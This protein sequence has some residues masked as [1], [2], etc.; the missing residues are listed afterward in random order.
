MTA[1]HLPVETERKAPR[2]SA[3]Q[4]DQLKAAAQLQQK[5]HSD[6]PGCGSEFIV[7][8][9]LGDQPGDARELG[10]GGAA[11]LVGPALKVLVADDN[12]DAA[13]TCATL[14]EVLGHRVE[15]AYTGQRALELAGRFQ[16]H[17]LLLDI[18]LPDLNGYELAKQIRAA[19]WARRTV[20]I[21]VTG[22]G[23]EEHQRRALEAGF[24]HHLTKPLAAETLE[25]LLQSVSSMLRGPGG[26]GRQPP[27]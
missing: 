7:R 21:A 27:C 11:A 16:P 20:L 8:L 9:P 14:I 5:A 18:G 6:G 19:T 10:D 24:D 12:R 17:V 25:F 2:K 22:W 23:Q 1:R 13:D 15:T 4:E 3:N 26:G